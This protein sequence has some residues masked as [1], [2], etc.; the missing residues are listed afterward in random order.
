MIREH[1]ISVLVAVLDL[2]LSPKLDKQLHFTRRDRLF[3]Y[4]NFIDY[5]RY[6][7]RRPTIR[8]T[9]C[10]PADSQSRVD[11]QASRRRATIYRALR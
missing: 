1:P 2:H 6:Y 10:V 7:V 4:H 11:A 9:C 5:S 8:D 3:N